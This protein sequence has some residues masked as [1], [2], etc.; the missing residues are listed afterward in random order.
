MQLSSSEIFD[1]IGQTISSA[2]VQQF[3][4]DEVQKDMLSQ[5]PNG[6][7]FEFFV[8]SYQDD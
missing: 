8:D 6:D 4:L 7:K 5:P 2:K 1:H 3:D